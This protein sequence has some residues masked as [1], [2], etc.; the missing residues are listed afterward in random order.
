MGVFNHE[1][2]SLLQKVTYNLSK[3]QKVSASE[4]L[5]GIGVAIY[6]MFLAKKVIPD[7]RKSSSDVWGDVLRVPRWIKEGV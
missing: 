5:V 2:L 6:P 7:L 1:D 4:G 3:K